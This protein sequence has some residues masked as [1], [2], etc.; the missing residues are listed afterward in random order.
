[1]FQNCVQDVCPW[2]RSLTKLCP[3]SIVPG[4]RTSLVYPTSFLRKSIF[5][6]VFLI[7][8]PD[9]PPPLPTTASTCSILYKNPSTVSTHAPFGTSSQLSARLTQLT[10]CP[11]VGL[12]SA[13]TLSACPSQRAGLGRLDTQLV[14][15]LDVHVN[16]EG[17]VNNGPVVPGGRPTSSTSCGGGGSSGSDTGR[18][19]SGTAAGNSPHEGLRGADRGGENAGAVTS[20]SFGGECG[21]AMEKPE[22]RF[23]EFSGAF[24]QAMEQSRAEFSGAFGHAMESRMGG[25][26]ADGRCPDSASDIRS[27]FAR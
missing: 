19:F 27:D 17:G 2:S 15:R 3:R 18:V 7:R 1:M 11:S 14:E 5:V 22:N 24:G 9:H 23:S 10:S 21:R 20:P 26:I 13:H 8:P 12:G 4:H 6:S 16:R 25:G